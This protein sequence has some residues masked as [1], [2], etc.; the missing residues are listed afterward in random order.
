[1]ADFLETLA[2]CILLVTLIGGGFFAIIAAIKFLGWCVEEI[3]YNRTVSEPWDTTLNSM[4]D[5]GLPVALHN[6][7]NITIG[8]TYVSILTEYFGQEFGRGLVCSRTTQKR[9]RDYVQRSYC[10]D[11]LKK[12]EAEQAK[13][14]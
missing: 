3:N 8:G 1:M 7:S 10:I 9:L 12:A 11:I 14:V 5:S 6:S 2:A 4:M 13:G